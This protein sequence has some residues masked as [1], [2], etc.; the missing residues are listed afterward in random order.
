MNNEPGRRL[1]LSCTSQAACCVLLP[2]SLGQ[3]NGQ[4]EALDELGVADAGDE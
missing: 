3:V 2:L 1:S 4:V